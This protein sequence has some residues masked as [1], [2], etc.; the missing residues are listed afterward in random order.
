MMRFPRWHGH[1]GW[2]ANAHWGRRVLLK[3]QARKEA[4]CEGEEYTWR[5]ME[6]PPRGCRMRW[7][8]TRTRRRR[9][10]NGTDGGVEKRNVT[11]VGP[12]AGP[13]LGSTRARLHESA[14]RVPLSSLYV[15]LFLFREFYVQWLLKK[16]HPFQ[17]VVLTMS[18]N[19]HHS[20]LFNID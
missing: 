19:I 1:G 7:R 2:K 9:T 11:P 4:V 14:S 17:E 16:A 15:F 6:A 5:T 20:I 13:L 12:S 3:Q 18:K 10:G 8:A